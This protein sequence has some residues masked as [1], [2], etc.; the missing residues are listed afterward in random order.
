MRNALPGWPLAPAA[1]ILNVSWAN[2]LFWLDMLIA[3]VFNAALLR[4]G[5]MKAYRAAPPL[6]LGLILADFVTG[7]LWSLIGTLLHLSLFCTF[8][9]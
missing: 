3:W 4:Y 5:G 1:Y 2:N 8:S 7:S 9:T 6:F